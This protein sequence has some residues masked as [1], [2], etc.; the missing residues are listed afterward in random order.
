VI[1][2]RGIGKR[3]GPRWA[4]RGV[5]LAPRRGSTTALIGPSGCGKSTL[6]RMLIGLIEPTDG[7]LLQSGNPVLDWTAARRKIGYVIQD[8]GLLPHMTVR[9]N[10]LLPGIAHRP[11]S[12]RDAL[13]VRLMTL[14]PMVHLPAE[15]LDRY[16]SE[17]SGG[18]R[19]RVALIRALILDPDLL[20]LDEPLGALDPQI[21]SGLQRELRTVFRETGK[22]VVLVTHDLAEAAYLAD[23]IVLMREGGIEQR[24]S[25][26]DLS[27]RPE[28]PFVERFI[29][30]QIERVRALFGGATA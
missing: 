1:E 29:G 23:D 2:A 18:Q 8:G 3:Y 4:V 26:Q 5:D 28:T 15:L 22:A 19:Q 30:D 17:L 12:E 14:L 25:F 9:Q 10:T 11:R 21:R 27:Q 16:P 6:L 13:A 7:D 20:L 24:G